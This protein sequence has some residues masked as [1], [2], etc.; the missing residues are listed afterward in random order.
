LIEYELTVDAV[1]VDDFTGKDIKDGGWS[2]TTLSDGETCHFQSL[3]EGAIDTLSSRVGAESAYRMFVEALEKRLQNDLAEAEAADQASA[4]IIAQQADV[5][6]SSVHDEVILS[7]S[8]QTLFPVGTR[9]LMLG[10]VP[11]VPEV[12]KTG[13]ITAIRDEDSIFDYDIRL[14]NA[15]RATVAAFA[16]EVVQLPAVSTF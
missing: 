7:G 12:S 11:L 10:V 3:V 4:L 5:I 6:L 8:G 16:N 13:E 14:D 2:L 15:D 1:V 9:V